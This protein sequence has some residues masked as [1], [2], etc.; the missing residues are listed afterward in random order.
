MS[1]SPDGAHLASGSDDTTVRLWDV[2]TG[3]VRRVL[4]GHLAQVLAV[5]WRAPLGE[6]P[7]PSAS[8]ATSLAS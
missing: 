2:T 7:T 3:K 1:F 5:A 4:H 8:R 6:W